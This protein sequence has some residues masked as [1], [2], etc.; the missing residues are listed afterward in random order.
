MNGT[1]L[2]T[3]QWL[4]A[5]SLTLLA[6]AVAGGGI[7]CVLAWAEQPAAAVAD[8]PGYTVPEVVVI[9]SGRQRDHSRWIGFQILEEEVRP[10]E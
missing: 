9:E 1:I 10:N 5:L 3:L 4:S 2:E 7:A 6:A 8:G